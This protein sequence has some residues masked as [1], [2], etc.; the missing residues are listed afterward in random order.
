MSI[1]LVAAI[2]RNGV[3]GSDGTLP[4]HIPEDLKRFKELTSGHVVL[5]G[6]KTWESIPEKFRPLP[7]RT[8]LVITRQTSLEVPTGVEVFSSIESALSA[9]AEDDV[10][11]IGGAEIYRQTISLADRLE[12]THVDRD[13]AGDALFPSIDSA[14][15]KET[16]RTPGDGFSFVTYIRIS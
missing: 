16:Q 10:Y 8:N 14:V 9:H 7:N 11:V 6:R 1:I 13:V 15:W 3:I 4:W 2:S 5:M 12:I